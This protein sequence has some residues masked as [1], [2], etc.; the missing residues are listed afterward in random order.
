MAGG[1]VLMVC[2]GLPGFRRVGAGSSGVSVERCRLRRL[3]ERDRSSEFRWR[4]DVGN[5]VLLSWG[6]W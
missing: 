4:D 6:R 1:S 5:V 3:L 2:E